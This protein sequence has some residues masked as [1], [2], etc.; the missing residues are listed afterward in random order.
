VSIVGPDFNGGLPVPLTASVTS[1][2]GTVGFQAG[3]DL[4]SRGLIVANDGVIAGVLVGYLSNHL[5][6]NTTTISGIPAVVGNSNSRLTA[7]LS[8]PTAGV[9]ATYFAGGFSTDLLAKFDF[10]SLNQNSTDNLAFAAPT[11]PFFAAYSNT[12]ATSVVDSTVAANLNYRFDIYPNFWIQPTVG[13]QFTALSYGGGAAELGLS[14][15]Q[16]VMI[17]G[18]ARVGTTSVFSNNILLTSTLT[19]LAYDDVVVN[20]GFIPGASFNG[21]N[22]LANSDRG[23]LRGRGILAF[24]FDFGQGVTSFVQ[25]DVH[26]GKGLF[27]A[28]GKAGIR[29]QW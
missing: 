2:S 17:Q 4:T 14:D 13:A 23:Q 29:Y 20:G 19:G 9:Y 25:G 12:G 10:L 26:G 22:L 16:Q 27:G 1:R 21:N 18:G 7:T 6:L 24:N 8:G 3:A 5:T 15:G 11:G 28:G